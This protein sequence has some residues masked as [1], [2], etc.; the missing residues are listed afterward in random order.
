MPRFNLEFQPNFYIYI[1]TSYT[2]YNFT[3][4]S[5]GHN[6]D[7]RITKNHSRITKI[8]RITKITP[9]HEPLRS[10]IT[11]SKLYFMEGAMTFPGLLNDLYSESLG[12][13]PSSVTED[14]R[15]QEGLSIA[16]PLQTMPPQCQRMPCHCPQGKTVH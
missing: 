15:D 9:A 1:F 10:Y 8:P 4:Y 12:K 14:Q 7:P 13:V 6:Q 5:L 16:E 3:S 2:I 11:S